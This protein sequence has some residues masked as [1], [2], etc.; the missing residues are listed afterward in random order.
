M[1]IYTANYDA[2]KPTPRA[3]TVPLNSNFGIGVGVCYNSK[4]VE[5]TKDSLKL[6]DKSADDVLGNMAIFNMESDG[7]EGRES[8]NV[9]VEAPGLP[10]KEL[11]FSK[12]IELANG[13]GVIRESIADWEGT[14]LVIPDTTPKP[15]YDYSK[16]PFQAV[17]KSPSYDDRW[18]FLTYFVDENNTSL[19]MV[20]NVTQ[21]F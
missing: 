12:S 20:N 8:Y 15:D 16:N 5:I 19:A 18:A 6:N 17:A 9:E 7:N 4:P 13:Q 21:G 2:T 14:E 11:V 10:S 3:I 1:N